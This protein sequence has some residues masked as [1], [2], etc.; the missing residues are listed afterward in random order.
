[1][2]TAGGY[3]GL[4]NLHPDDREKAIEAFRES[5][6]A[7]NKGVSVQVRNVFGEDVIWLSI[8]IFYLASVKIVQFIMRLFRTAVN[9]WVF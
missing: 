9:K 4:E 2:I 5:K 6:I 8:K 3:D 1:M 7:G